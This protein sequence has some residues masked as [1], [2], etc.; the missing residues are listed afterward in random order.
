LKAARLY[1][2]GNKNEKNILA[3]CRVDP[4]L[5]FGRNGLEASFE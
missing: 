3:R 4:L 1:E 5:V 2:K